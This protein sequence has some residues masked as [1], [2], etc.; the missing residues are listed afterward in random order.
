[1][2]YKP[3]RALTHFIRLKLIELIIVEMS[4]KPERALTRK[5]CGGVHTSPYVEMSY[6]P[7]R[8]LTQSTVAYWTDA[9]K[10]R[11]EL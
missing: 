6:K 1:M 8:A 2:S 7:E 9:A 3:E 10:C 4:Y 5:M 11:N